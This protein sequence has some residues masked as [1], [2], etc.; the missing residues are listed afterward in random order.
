MD[1]KQLPPGLGTPPPAAMDTDDESVTASAGRKRVYDE[2]DI[3]VPVEAAGDSLGPQQTPK[4]PKL[5]AAEEFIALESSSEGEFA[6]DS[7]DDGEASAEDLMLSNVHVDASAE[8]PRPGV[9]QVRREPDARESQ[10]KPPAPP[11]DGTA[12][13]GLQAEAGG[14]T[15]SPTIAEIEAKLHQ[16]AAV[17][18]RHQVI[19]ATPGK[20]LLI[21]VDPHNFSGGKQEADQFFRLLM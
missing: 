13:T 15:P 7:S 5:S 17:H 12:M 2:T 14:P 8:H 4:K 6:D 16:L 11:S 9:P 10:T 1:D 20:R 18:F 21:T 3:P 19:A